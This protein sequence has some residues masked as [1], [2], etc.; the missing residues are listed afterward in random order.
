MNKEKKCRHEEKASIIMFSSTIQPTSSTTSTTTGLTVTLSNNNQSEDNDESMSSSTSST[1][2]SSS[3][4]SLSSSNV[5]NISI[6]AAAESTTTPVQ[7]TPAPITA[8]P[9]LVANTNIKYVCEICGIL[10]PSMDTLRQHSS[11]HN[12]VKIINHSEVNT[13][14]IIKLDDNLKINCEEDQYE[15]RGTSQVASSKISSIIAAAKTAATVSVAERS[16]AKKCSPAIINI[17]QSMTV[18]NL[19]DI[20]SKLSS[21]KPSTSC[22]SSISSTPIVITQVNGVKPAGLLSV[23][24]DQK[25]SC[26]NGDAKKLNSI[27]N[28]SAA[29]VNDNNKST[30]FFKPDEKP[31]LSFQSGNSYYSSL[32][33]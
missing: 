4:L 13:M 32:L 6:L 23:D 10:M 2:S 14:K 9:L 30:I 17:P 21:L 28:T 25:L 11:T 19:K 26:L 20:S 27:E 15:S 24:E 5:G 33:I 3:P 8:Y 16:A 29:V 1:S 7:L 12:D 18:F 22:P 31:E